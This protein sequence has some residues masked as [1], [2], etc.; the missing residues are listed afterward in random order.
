MTQKI[1]NALETF[2][3]KKNATFDYDDKREN[4]NI[5]RISQNQSNFFL[6]F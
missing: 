2:K 4:F 6:K 5:D 1:R 3:Q